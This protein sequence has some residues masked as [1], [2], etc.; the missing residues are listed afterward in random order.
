MSYSH[1]Q[2]KKNPK[3]LNRAAEIIEKK[4]VNLKFIR[5]AE[6]VCDYNF[7]LLD[8]KKRLTIG[9]FKLLKWYMKAVNK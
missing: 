3:R 7:G 5:E 9:E 4:G 8:E 2:R 1:T 6:D